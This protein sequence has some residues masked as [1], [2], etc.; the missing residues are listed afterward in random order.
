MNEVKKNIL[1]FFY[2]RQLKGIT[3]PVHISVLTEFE[4]NIGKLNMIIMSLNDEGYLN[5]KPLPGSSGIVEIV[6]NGITPK[7][8]EFVDE[9]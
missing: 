8:M 1:K 3:E 6:I 4:E 7:G 2:S 9:L 5:A